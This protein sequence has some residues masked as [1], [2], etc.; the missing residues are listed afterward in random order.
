MNQ[1]AEY[2]DIPLNQALAQA[3][4]AKLAHGDRQTGCGPSHPDGDRLG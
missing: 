1:L 2:L 3:F 4:G